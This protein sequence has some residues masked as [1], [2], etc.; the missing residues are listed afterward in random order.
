MTVAKDN[1]KEQQDIKKQIEKENLAPNKEA[2]K[3]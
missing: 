1:L 2:I 3:I